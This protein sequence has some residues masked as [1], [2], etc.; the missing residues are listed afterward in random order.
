MRLKIILL[1]FHTSTYQALRFKVKRVN[2][3]ASPGYLNL[4][5]CHWYAEGFPL[6]K[7]PHRSL[8]LSGLCE[9]LGEGGNLFLSQT[10][11]EFWPE[12]RKRQ[13]DAGMECFSGATS[14][15]ATSC[16]ESWPWS[17]PACFSPPAP[18]SPSTIPTMLRWHDWYEENCAFRLNPGHTRMIKN[19]SFQKLQRVNGLLIQVSSSRMQPLHFPTAKQTAYTSLRASAIFSSYQ[20]S[21][22]AQI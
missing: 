6:I 5:C 18:P 8:L 20:R 11:K 1:F 16:S 22:T 21:W 7:N 4:S 13:G 9:V 10:W 14:T 17:C 19:S 2:C 15:R 12:T 3:Y